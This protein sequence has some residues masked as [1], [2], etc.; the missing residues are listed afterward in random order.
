MAKV[1]PMVLAAVILLLT[2]SALAV[3]LSYAPA[4]NIRRTM[5]LLGRST[6]EHP[7]TVRILVYGQS[8][9]EQAWHLEVRDAL[10][11]RFPDANIVWANHARGGCAS[12]CLINY[13][14]QDVNDWDP[15]LVI[16]HVYGSH[17]Y[18]E[19]IIASMR[20][21]VNPGG[22]NTEV[23]ITNDH[24]TGPD[25]WSD[26]MSYTYVPGF[27]SE[28]LCG[29]I[30]VRHQ[31]IDY[32]NI[33]YPEPRPTP[34]PLTIDGTHLN[35]EGNRLLASLIIPYLV[36]DPNW[37]PLRATKFN[38]PHWS[39]GVSRNVNLSWMAGIDADSHDVYFGTSAAP[40]FV[41]NQTGTTF[42]PGTMEPNKTYYW[43]IDPRN[44]NG[45]TAGLTTQFTT[46]TGRG[47]GLL[48]E[49]FDNADLTNLKAVWTD[50]VIDCNW[51]SY[52][53]DPCI[54]SDTFSV[55]WTGQVEPLWSET[56][57]FYT[58]TDDGARLWVD[59]NLIINKWQN[60]TATEWSGTAALTAGL[61][62]D[63]KMEYYDNTGDA[64]A[65]LRWSSASQTKQIVP[66]ARLYKYP[67]PGDLDADYEIDLADTQLF[68]DQWL[69][70]PDCSEPNCADLDESGLVDFYDFAVLGAGW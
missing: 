48:A 33:H 65:Q 24:Y 50:A 69:T 66:Q 60:Q 57:T 64:L 12:D 61:K 41:Q 38:P 15:D 36:W 63:I 30:D 23:L 54:G 2:S 3:N 53:P 29:F 22:F 44:K 11:A 16:F 43:R 37:L 67:Q 26:L 5:S 13:V 49:H 56:Y 46:G 42:D 7:N 40:P 34:Y 6:P 55:R 51:R 10:I 28:Y 31:W 45:F 9:S 32:L 19:Q 1:K 39:T 21:N 14:Q 18:Y 20:S 59:G 8:I 58:K 35:D 70:S 4:T 17:I 47:T 68:F 27:A 52:S 25:T 62:Y